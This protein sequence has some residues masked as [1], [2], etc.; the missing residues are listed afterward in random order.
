MNGSL[1]HHDN[2]SDSCGAGMATRKT[3]ENA[4]AVQ[5]RRL[6]IDSRYGQ[7]HLMTAYPRSGG[8]DERTPVLMLHGDGGSG[9]G[10]RHVA[11]RLGSD[12]S[13]YA[14]DLPGSGNSDGPSR[15]SIANHAAALADLLDALGLREVDVLGSGRGA[16]A[17]FELAALRPLQ[18]RRL[19]I[20]G[21]APQAASS[22]PL[23]QLASD[24][25]QCAEDAA[26]AVV[27]QIRGFLD[28]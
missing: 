10:F 9:A 16:Q 7:L 20:A 22:K 4:D 18:V 5:L 2:G 23:L 25:A 15:P 11:A 26:P 6:Y 24:P 13:V 3:R 19:L 14:P 27:A 28:R 17:A 1:M 8:F 21:T 12:R